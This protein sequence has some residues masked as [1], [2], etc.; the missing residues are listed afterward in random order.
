MSDTTYNGWRN[1]ETWCV[2]LWIDND[3]GLYHERND[4]VREAAARGGDVAE[5]CREWLV[6][7]APDL[8]ASL[9]SDLLN[10]AMSEVDWHELAEH[11]VRDYADEEEAEEQ[12]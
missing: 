7:L 2:G 8:G 1:Y 12:S 9:W 5:A 4:L 3:E 10:A 6:G 11:W